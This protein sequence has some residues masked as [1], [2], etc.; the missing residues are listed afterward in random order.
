ML[1]NLPKKIIKDGQEGPMQNTSMS[2][3]TF[4]PDE[5]EK[6]EP[7]DEQEVMDPIVTDAYKQF[8]R[9]DLLILVNRMKR[10][11]T[12]KAQQQQE[13]LV[14]QMNEEGMGDLEDEDDEEYGAAYFD[15]RGARVQNIGEP[16]A[17]SGGAIGFGGMNDD[18]V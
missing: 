12:S 16:Q 18:A 9:E 10:L 11:T 6:G 3:I 8:S 1:C 14:Q 4:D 2:S 13:R 15:P 5:E 7:L 17:N